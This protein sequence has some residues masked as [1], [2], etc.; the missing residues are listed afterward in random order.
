M[1]SI[2]GWLNLICSIVIMTMDCI[3]VVKFFIILRFYIEHKI[4]TLQSQGKMLTKFHK[5]MIVWIAFNVIPILYNTFNK[6]IF[7]IL[8]FTKIDLNE[9]FQTFV[10]INRNLIIPL[11]YFL[12]FNSLLYLFYKQ[13]QAD[14]K[15]SNLAS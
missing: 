5:I 7:S 3:Y 8:L 6:S 12:L 14:V 15:R 4:Q 10:V 11:C 1:N 2:L 13:G 9:D